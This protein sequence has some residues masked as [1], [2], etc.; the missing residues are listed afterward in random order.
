MAA[1]RTFAVWL[2]LALFALGGGIACNGDDDDSEP[3]TPGDDDDATEEALYDD[4]D[5]DGVPDVRDL[6]PDTDAGERTDPRG[7]SARQSSACGV[8]LTSPGDGDA[9]P[10]GSVTF[11]FEGDCEGYR[12]YVSG[13]AELPVHDTVLVG[14]LA[15]PGELTVATTDL[16]VPSATDGVRYWAV[17]G[18][19]RGHSFLTPVRSF[20]TEAP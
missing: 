10:S 17:E 15:E 7:C 8:S 13:A 3:P 19:A 18:S 14:A 4:A 5:A 2:S 9:F 12:I 11:A 6:C 1:M 16:E 20:T